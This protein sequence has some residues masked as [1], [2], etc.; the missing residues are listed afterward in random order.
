MATINDLKSTLSAALGLFRRL[1]D[2]TAR[3][4][5]DAEMLPDDP[6]AS[7]TPEAAVTLLLGLMTAPT[8]KDAPDCARLY[9]QLPLWRINQGE[10]TTRGTCEFVRLGEAH[11]FAANM[12]SLGDAFGEF[13]AN[14]LRN[15]MEAPE[16]TIEP[17]EVVVGGGP[18]TAFAS[19]E[20]LVLAEGADVGGSVVFNLAPLGGGQLPDDAPR[21]RLDQYAIVPAAIFQVLRKAL[22]GKDDPRRATLPREAVEQLFAT[23]G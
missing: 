5:Q 17:G 23:E 19:V 4:L 1:V 7:A 6:G 16:I 2:E 13:F 20:Y 15:Y 9:A 22:N 12:A 18:G 11:P 8:P 21:A 10:T 3:H 14:L